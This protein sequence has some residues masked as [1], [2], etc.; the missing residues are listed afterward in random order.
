MRSVYVRALQ[1][2]MEPSVDNPVQTLDER[3]QNARN[4]SVIE[5]VFLLVAGEAS[6]Q[7]L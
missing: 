6:E 3:K 4:W 2:S 1:K 5:Y 7:R